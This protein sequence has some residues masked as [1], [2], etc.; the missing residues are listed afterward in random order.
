MR[1]YEQIPHTADL[2]ARIYAETLPGIFENA[3]FAMFDMLADLEGLVHEE[4]RVFSVEGP[5]A[6]SVL[7]FWLN[8]LLY[9]SGANCIL[10]TEFH[11]SFFSGTRLVAT[12][13]GGYDKYNERVR[14]EIKAATYHD[15]DLLKT[16]TGYQ[17][18]LVFDV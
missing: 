8:D 4:E 3:A 1:K 16:D 18:D 13:K 11:V 2:A 9:G 17:V 12:A 14:A 15:V 10:F 5:D 7:V 6:E